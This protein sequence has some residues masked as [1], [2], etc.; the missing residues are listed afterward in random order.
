MNFNLF[1]QGKG[2][3]SRWMD[4]VFYFMCALLIATICCYGIF[5]LKVYL[6]Q[7]NINELDQKMLVYGS[8]EEKLSEKEVLDYKKKLA[9]YIGIINNHKISLHLFNFIE[10]NTLPNVWFSSIT[11]SSIFSYLY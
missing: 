11:A 7:Q 10:Q 9:D 6:Q 4:V 5:L 8:P 2:K 1:S 3:E